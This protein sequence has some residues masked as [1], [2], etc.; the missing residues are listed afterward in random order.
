MAHRLNA[1]GLASVVPPGLVAADSLFLLGFQEHWK[2]TEHD[3]KCRSL[4]SFMKIVG[5]KNLCNTSSQQT[6]WT[7]PLVAL[8]TYDK[9]NA[10]RVNHDDA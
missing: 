7:P 4:T 9:R 5:R 2:Q 1:G 6:A 8:T 10:L 3:K